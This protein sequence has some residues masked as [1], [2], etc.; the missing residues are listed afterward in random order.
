M[1]DTLRVQNA[2]DATPWQ[3]LTE[4]F[5]SAAKEL[6]VGQMVHLSNFNLF[7]SMSALELMDPKMD[8][9]MLINGAVPQP[10]SV[11][12]KNGSIALAFTS[13]RDV[14]ATIDELFRCESGW[15]NG[16]PLQ[17][18]LLTSV[19][20]HKEPINAL[21]SQL[22]SFDDL[23]ART[24]IEEVLQHKLAAKT[25]AETL[26]LVMSTVCLVMLK[27][28][29]IVRDVVV[30]GDIYEE[31]DFSPA[32]GFDIG[33]LEAF[34]YDT[35]QALLR[36]TEQRL[37]AVLVEQK[38]AASSKK[39]SKKKGNKKATAATSES[40]SGG[41]EGL[42]Q[43]ARIGSL[44][45]EALLRRVRLRRALFEA[46]TGLG[47]AEGPSLDLQR[48]RDQF[49]QTKELLVG[50]ETE[51]LELDQECF[52]G[53]PFGV[54]KTIS[55]LL[56]SGSPPRDIKIPSLDDA[57]VIQKK[58]MDQLVAACS[59]AEWSSME[60]LRI[61]LSD[62]SRQQPNIIARSYVLLFLYANQKIYAKYS[63]T[64]WLSASM[65][66]NGVPSVLMSTQEGVLFSTRVIETLY[67]SLKLY[68]HNRSRQRARIEY[69]LEEWS[70]LQL[71]AAG[72][73]DKFTTEMAIPKTAYPRYFTA[74]TLEQAVLLMI[75][76]ILLGFELDLYAPSE[77]GT[78]YWYLDYLHGS[79][80]QN[81]NVTWQFVEKMKQ[82]MPAR[83][84]AAP[85]ASETDA[86]APTAPA[87]TSEPD[88]KTLSKK[89]KHGKSKKSPAAAP[90][91]PAAAA[92]TNGPVK[93]V[94]STKARFLREINYNEMQRSVMRAYFQLFS[95]LEREQLVQVVTPTYSSTLIRFEHRFAAFQSIHFP[96][97]LT[98]DDYLKNSDFSPYKVD[99]IYKSAEEC[100]KV[101]RAHG[102]ELLTSGNINAGTSSSSSCTGS[103]VSVI[104]GAEVEALMKVAISNSVAL[105]RRDQL[106][107]VSGSA[108][109]QQHK[110]AQ[111]NG[112]AS[113]P[114]SATAVAT[115]TQLDF[116]VHP[117]FPVVVFPERKA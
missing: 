17:Q 44:I 103:H 84:P 52:S 70:V 106:P 86:P 33:I 39:S 35:V 64:E 34:S 58:L 99:L 81:L 26:L 28:D 80:L 15:F 25:A 108:S 9:G 66:M 47:T 85:K 50:L 1:N 55:R 32:N 73:D 27:T 110:K 96:A 111:K 61:F 56:L 53:K 88:A 91:A 67:E 72:I 76:Y 115:I 11:R 7:D 45:C 79:R 54:D 20:L 68:L 40:S 10:I 60:E 62:F 59:P 37:E 14:L 18:T 109:K 48:A 23:I 82:L 49:Q 21:L 24:D 4:L 43:S 105:L 57:I 71:E 6:K 12:M 74:W 101:A 90:N 29:I 75:H 89:S 3:D 93:D 69:L 114:P 78:V 41:Y 117:H 36:F 112:A 16:Q 102:E 46:F 8:S 22:V 100:F 107:Q 65:V 83:K 87:E 98:H 30:R 92:A 5:A 116:S 2:G 95:A 19:Y 113:A 13:A 51:Q 77:Y 38:A 104:H 42:H 63:F 31:E 97:A 94:D